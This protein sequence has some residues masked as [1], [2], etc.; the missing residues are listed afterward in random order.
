MPV[1][2][3]SGIRIVTFTNNNS[4]GPISFTSISVSGNYSITNNCPMQSDDLFLLQGTSCTVEVVFSPQTAGIH[5]AQLTYVGT[6]EGIDFTETVALTGVAE[7]VE[8]GELSLSPASLDFGS[9]AVGSSSNP[10]PVT[11][12]NSGNAAVDIT[13]IS[14]TSPFAHSNDCPSILTASGSCTIMVTATP[15]TDGAISGS[16]TA[17]GT[18]PQGTIRGE[19]TLSANG[20]TP[21]IVVS[22]TQLSFPDASVDTPSQPQVVTVS[23]QGTAAVTVNAIST[24][25]DFSQSNNCGT[26]LAAG[27]SCDIEIVFTPQTTGSAS[28][29]LNIDTSDGL[30]RILLSGSADAP[31]SNPVADLLRPYAGDN[32]NL[33]SLVDVIAEACPSGRLSDRLQEDCNAVVGAASGGDG[34]TAVALQQVLP[35]SATKANATSRQGGE[36][37][38]GNLGRRIAALRNGARGL[39]FN[40][41]DLR[42]DDQTLPIELIADAYRETVRRGGGASADNPLLASRLGVFVTGDITTGERDETDLESGLD[43]DTVGITIGADYRITNQF[44]LGGAVGFIDTEAE[45]ENDAGDLDT[46][47]VSLSLFGTYYS[48]QNY[49]VDFSATLGSNDFEQKRR[50]VYTLDGLADVSQQLKADYDGDMVSLFVGSGYDFNRGPWSFGPRADLEYIRSDVDGFSEEISD[51]T[52]DGGGWATRVDETDQRWLTLNLGGKVS[53]THSADWGVLIPY[54][55]LDWLHE[56]EDD[57]Q[58]ITAHFIEDPAGM[59]IEIQTDDPDRDYLRLRFGTSAQFQNGVVGFIDYG[60]ILAHSE[61]SAHTI[62]AGLRMEF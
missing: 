26:Q 60:T 12:T 11:L 6:D 4:A 59:G 21:D 7:V 47:G 25:G 35:E 56:F 18:G 34:N 27:G 52:A 42:I 3:S 39:S 22:D 36:T 16:L 50:I 20:T 61:W 57:S 1:G 10:L 8:F 46:Q 5:N 31:S 32:P 51:P 24:E 30:T 43:F 55:R 15:A 45:L 53:Y 23:N 33:L 37:Q 17:S 44:I 19:I 28:G 2:N 49:F 48:P 13:S 38:I 40:G 29:A 54:A 58:V 14:T 41:L 62:S 9:V